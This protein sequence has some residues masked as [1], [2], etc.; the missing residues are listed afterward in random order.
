MKKAGVFVIIDRTHVLIGH[1]T[2]APQHIWSIPKGEQDSGEEIKTTAIRELEEESGI[3]VDKKHLTFIG[4]QE[5][6][7]NPNTILF[8]Y[9][10]FGKSLDV[11]KLKCKSKIPNS[12]IPEID[13]YKLVPIDELDKWVHEAQYKLLQKSKV[14][15]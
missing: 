15:I 13:G 8:G 1:V 12:D 10:L 3:I 2:N 7:K 6:A 5:Y 11:T 9:T 4:S 14:H